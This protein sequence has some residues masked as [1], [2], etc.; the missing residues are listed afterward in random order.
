MAR[1]LLLLEN[2]QN[3]ALLADWLSQHYQV[4]QL[5]PSISMESQFD[6]C[7]IDGP[8]LDRCWSEIQACKKAQDPIFLPVIFLTAHREVELITRHLWKTIDELIRLPIEKTELQARVEMLLR[9]RSLSLALKLRNEDLESFFHAM[10]HDLRAPLRAVKSFAE[11][12]EDS[13]GLSSKGAHYVQ[14][15]RSASG[16]M[17]ELIDALI[18]FARVGY[19]EQTPQA[20]DLQ[21][22]LE[23]CLQQLEMEI[24]KRA[25]QIQV[26]SPMP[27]VEGYPFLFKIILTNLLSNALKFVEPGQSPVVL[28]RCQL[29]QTMCRIEIEDHGIGM[30]PEQQNR[31]FRPFVQFHGVEEYEGIGLGLAT[32]R[33]AVELM[34]GRIGVSS[35]PGQGSLFWLNLRLFSKGAV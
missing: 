9:T 15:I 14:R 7:L 31:L 17:Q 6:V 10:T 3:R 5:D 13:P 32:V 24:E 26:L 27:I 2:K 33:K 25:A 21:I 8:S 28:L 18:S 34:G 1:I 30:T 4:I 35:T 23:R 19:N 22:L 12:L 29:S 20:V 16:Q 11:L